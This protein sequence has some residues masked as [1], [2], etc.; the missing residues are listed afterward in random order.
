MNF[1]VKM[2]DVHLS[3]SQAILREY[4]QFIFIFE[5]QKFISILMETVQYHRSFAYRKC[6]KCSAVFKGQS[7]QIQTQSPTRKALEQTSHPCLGSAKEIIFSFSL[8]V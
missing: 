8:T 1:S 5:S 7:L 2:I 6:G 4:L 3:S